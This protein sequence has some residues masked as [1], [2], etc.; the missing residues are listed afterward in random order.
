M[1]SSKT[2]KRTLNDIWCFFNDSPV[3]SAVI[4]SLLTILGTQI[5]KIYTYIYWLPF[6]KFY[7]V[8]THYFEFI[9][10]DKYES[11]LRIAIVVL[12]V[13]PTT[14]LFDFLKKKIT[15]TLNLKL[16]HS[17]IITFMLYILFGFV[18]IFLGME[19]ARASLILNDIIIY[20][21]CSILI[22]IFKD[23][24]GVLIS[25]KQ[26]KSKIS[27]LLLLMIIIFLISISSCITLV[28]GLNNVVHSIYGESKIIDEDKLIVFET[29]EQYYIIP[30][31]KKTN[32][33]IKIYRDSYVL[34]DK[35][36]Q[37]VVRKYYDIY[38]EYDTELEIDEK[39]IFESIITRWFL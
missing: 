1:E 20:I 10:L 8:P 31:K 30:C 22:I 18:E 5:Y 9:M 13:L 21:G 28:Y 19:I 26:S 27:K 11:F 12:F 29:S 23:L 33:S 4:I 32:N 17:I 2:I 6:L 35:N 14:I 7:R 38:D 39:Q 3:L 34:V 24:F 15:T 16:S 36:K 37:Q 25:R